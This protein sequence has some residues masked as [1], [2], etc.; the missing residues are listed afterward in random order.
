MRDVM[1]ARLRVTR[2]AV[3]LGAGATLASPAIVRGAAAARVVVIGAGFGG[4]T[5]AKY[6]KTWAPATQ[7]TLV[8]PAAQFVTCPYS[9]QVLGGLRTMASITHAYTKLARRVALVRDRAAAIDPDQRTVRLGGGR[10]LPYDRLIVSPGIDF[11]WGAIE[12]Y[13]E[14]A[15]QAMPHA[16]KAGPQTVLL[17]RQLEAMRDGGTVVIVAPDNPYRCPPGP[18]ERASMIAWYLKSRKPKSKLVILD[19][20][21]AFSKQGL[22]LDA[23]KRFYPDIIEWVPVSKGGKITK[24]DVKAMTAEDEFGTQ[25]KADVANVIPPQFAGKIARDAGLADPSGWCPVEP[26]SFESSLRKGIHVVGDATS[27]APMPKSGFVANNQGKVAAAAVVALLAGKTPADATWNNVCYS[28]VTP[29]YGF[30]VAN[31][32]HVAAGKFAEVPGSG[33]ISPRDADDKFR[34]QEAQYGDGWYASVTA[35]IFG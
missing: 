27:A 35:D 13:D 2:R 24:V 6:V 30:S 21:D 14:T 16:W 22:F 12:G 15:I 18:Y 4:A 9:N 33:G 34:K 23:W 31:V 8:E 1:R 3:L 11:R 26:H 17:R 20:K 19:A 25:H 5:A 32:I 28:H 7:V 29:D 10:T